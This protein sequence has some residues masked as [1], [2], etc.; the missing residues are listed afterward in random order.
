M[1]LVQ[2][3][4][5]VL[6]CVCLQCLPTIFFFTIS[7]L[8]TVRSDGYVTKLKKTQFPITLGNIIFSLYHRQLTSISKGCMLRGWK[9]Y[10][11]AMHVEQPVKLA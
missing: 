1:Q 7:Y 10:C 8:K 6:Q 2:L 11:T 5:G 4:W 9:H 3:L